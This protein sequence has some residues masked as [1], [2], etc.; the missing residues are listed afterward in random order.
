MQITLSQGLVALVDDEDFERI[1]KHKWYANKCGNTFYAARMIRNN[2]KRGV[3]QMQRAILL[4]EKGVFVDHIDGNGLNNLRNNLRLCTQAENLRNSKP[5]GG[6][7]KYKGVYW[8][9]PTKKWLAY[10]TFNYKRKHI[11]LFDL[12]SSAALAYNENAK[13]LFG[14]FARLNEIPA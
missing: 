13:E 6:T 11:G 4:P 3:L 12:E 9:E 2:D 5:I 14:S 8:H 1:N 10:I 7:S